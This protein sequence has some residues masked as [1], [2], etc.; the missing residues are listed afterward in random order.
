MEG[1]NVQTIDLSVVRPSFVVTTVLTP[2]CL[3][4]DEVVAVLVVRGRLSREAS[5]AKKGWNILGHHTCENKIVE[6]R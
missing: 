1:K 3:V 4:Q 2:W 6:I 5:Y